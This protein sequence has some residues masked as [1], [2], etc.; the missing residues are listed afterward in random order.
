M[1]FPKEKDLPLDVIKGM[2]LNESISRGVAA[3]V[4]APDD[5]QTIDPTT[6]PVGDG[7]PLALFYGRCLEVVEYVDEC[8]KNRKKGS[9]LVNV[10]ELLTV[11]LDAAR[12]MLEVS[13]P[14]ESSNQDD[15]GLAMAN[16]P[17]DNSY[18]AVTLP[19]YLP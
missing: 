5:A 17:R 10:A 2:R 12:M 4:Q 16:L 11:K 9:S 6:D 14:E 8:L 15:P 7:L 1:N 18:S 13:V 3:P 19:G